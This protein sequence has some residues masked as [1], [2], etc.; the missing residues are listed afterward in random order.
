MGYAAHNYNP[1]VIVDVG[2]L[3]PKKTRYWNAG[4]NDL[5]YTA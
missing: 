1:V 4:S 5:F 2:T 3:H